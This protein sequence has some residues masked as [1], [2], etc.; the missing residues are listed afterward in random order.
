MNSA[1]ETKT[2]SKPSAARTPLGQNYFPGMVLGLAERHPWS[3]HVTAKALDFNGDLAVPKVNGFEVLQQIRADESLKMM[4]VVTLTSL[5]EKCDLVPYKLGV[6]A[7]L[8]K[9]VELPQLVKA[10]KEL[11]AFCATI[12]EPLPG[13]IE[14]AE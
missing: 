1:I 4:P 11:G 10:V 12:N 3:S 14:K 2:N 6:N 13:S 5:H 8:V 7:Y 9:P